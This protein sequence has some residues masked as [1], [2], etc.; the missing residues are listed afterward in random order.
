MGEITSKDAFGRSIA[1]VI[2]K[3]DF[4]YNL[5]IGSWDG[6]GSTQCFIAGMLPLGQPKKLICLEI[7]N[8]RYQVLVEKVECF[9]FVEPIN[10]SSITTS[11]WLVK[12][13]DADIWNSPYNKIEKRFSRD[14]VHAWYQGHGK[15]LAGQK[16]GFLRE[17]HDTFD[18]VLIDGGAF[19]GYSE[20]VLLKNRTKCFFLDD[21]HR[22]FKCNQIYQEL[23]IDKDWSLSY[24]FSSVRNG[25]CVFIRNIL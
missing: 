16:R 8:G 13:F 14:E 1:A 24:E 3:F 15:I 10:M 17:C 12:D 5:E 22:A 6:T 7:D 21:V 20:F 2:Q 9:S 18:A 4:R 25:A 11:D 19:T 23:L